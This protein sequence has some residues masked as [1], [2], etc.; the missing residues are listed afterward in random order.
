MLIFISQN[1]LAFSFMD[2]LAYNDEKNSTVRNLYLAYSTGE[3]D[4]Q[5]C[6]T[7][8]DG[9]R[10]HDRQP[11]RIILLEGCKTVWLCFYR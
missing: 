3:E 1:A 5:A 10:L 6:W 8:Y 11:E 9:L 2:M 4:D 7:F